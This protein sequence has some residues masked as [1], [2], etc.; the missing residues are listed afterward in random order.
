MPKVELITNMGSNVPHFLNSHFLEACELNWQIAMELEEEKKHIFR[1]EIYNLTIQ[2]HAVSGKGER[3]KSL[4]QHKVNTVWL[5]LC[6][7][8]KYLICLDT[9]ETGHNWRD[10]EKFLAQKYFS[11]F[12]QMCYKSHLI[13]K[14]VLY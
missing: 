12:L 5:V 9:R 4:L 6:L 2:I 13:Y 10:M 1:N 8:T 11:T 7:L 3:N 14:S